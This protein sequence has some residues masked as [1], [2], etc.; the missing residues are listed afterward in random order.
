[1]K[2]KLKKVRHFTQ[3][4]I[5]HQNLNKANF[6]KVQKSESKTPS[7]SILS[8]HFVKEE[9]SE[10]NYSLLVLQSDSSLFSLQFDC[11]FNKLSLSLLSSPQIS[12]KSSNES[13]SDPLISSNPSPTQQLVSSFNS[14]CFDQNPLFH[15]RVCLVDSASQ[16]IS[17]PPL[18][19]SLQF[20][21]L[22]S[23]QSSPST[24]PS[25]SI[26]PNKELSSAP[27]D[28]KGFFLRF[29]FFF[30][31]FKQKPNVLGKKKEE[32]YFVVLKK[33]GVKILSIPQMETVK[34]IKFENEEKIKGGWIVSVM[35]GG[36]LCSPSSKHL[37]PSN[38]KPEELKENSQQVLLLLNFKLELCF[39]KL[40]DLS[41]FHTISLFQISPFSNF[42][43]FL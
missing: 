31:K 21:K 6:S 14:T 20:H 9:E 3:Q 40:F 39:Y 34:K 37:F 19:P 22:S 38:K 42:F 24:K 13:S 11:G 33:E 17:I 18:L 32:K 10:E 26:S 1:M 8:L 43:P 2:I 12:S 35:K 36:E 30:S 5:W 23:T 7:P 4:I 15:K 28:S 27:Q 25:P 29:T 16:P 41:I